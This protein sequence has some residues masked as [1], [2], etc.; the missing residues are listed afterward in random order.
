LGDVTVAHA[1]SGHGSDSV[2]GRRQRF[3]T[4]CAGAA[5]AN[6]GGFELFGGAVTQWLGVELTGDRQRGGKWRAGIG[7]AVG[8]SE[9]RAVVQQTVGVFETRLRG[10]EFITGVPERVDAA[11]VVGEKCR[12]VETHPDRAVRAEC[13]RDLEFLVEE[14]AGCDEL[15][16]AD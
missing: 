12:C 9:R 1:L 6:A 15:A 3:H 5:D 2:L 10:R 4:G 7:P 8:A 11:V 16:E 13:L 14:G